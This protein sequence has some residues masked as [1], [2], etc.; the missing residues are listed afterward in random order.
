VLLLKKYTSE[1]K[2]EIVKY[3]LSC[4]VSFKDTAEKYSVN[5]G[6]VQKWVA[7]YRHHGLK[8][9]TTINIKMNH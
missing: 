8:G 7:T 2:L 3:Y 9:L 6:D 5:K 1:L 4:K